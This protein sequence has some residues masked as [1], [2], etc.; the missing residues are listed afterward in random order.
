MLL[1]ASTLNF[2]AIADIALVQDVCGHSSAVTTLAV[3]SHLTDTR[4]QTA[5]TMYDP[6]CEVVQSR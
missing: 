4:R 2:S 5:A 6:T 3:Y 1:I